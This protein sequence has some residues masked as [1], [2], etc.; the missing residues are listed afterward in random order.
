MEFDWI[1]IEDVDDAVI[2]NFDCGSHVFIR[3][4]HGISK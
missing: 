3:L 1:N 4:L 2:D